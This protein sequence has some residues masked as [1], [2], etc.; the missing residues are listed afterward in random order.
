MV[1]NLNTKLVSFDAYHLI[2]S[3]KGR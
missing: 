2:F 1:K 3:L